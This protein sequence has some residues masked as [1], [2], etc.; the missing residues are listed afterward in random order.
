MSAIRDPGK[1]NE[2]TTLIDI[3]MEDIR[4]ITGVYLVRG[5]KTC[6]IDGGTRAQAPR[7]ARML[8]EAGAFPPDMILVTHPHW[9]HM[10]GIPWLR[11]EAARL[12]KRIEVL[13]LAEAVPL[14]ADASFNAIFAAGPAEAVADVTPLNEGDTIDLGGVVLRVY[15]MPG[16]CPGNLAALDVTNRN[17]FVGDALGDKVADDIFLPP[18]MPP[19]WDPVAFRA[20]LQ[21]MRQ[22]PYD[23]VCLAHFGCV[24]GEEARSIIDEAERVCDAWWAFYERHADRLNDIGF[25][26]KAM[27]Q[28]MHLGTPE[29]RPMTATMSVL[30]A[31]VN[32]A[33]TL[34]G[35]KVALI[36]R[37]A[38]RNVLNW[39]GKG[40]QMH[41][42]ANR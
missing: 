3:G 24:G 22:I 11:Q 33:G 1:I 35:T 23:T 28:E 27:R 42:A 21:R 38:F 4:G 17:L 20:S 12:G 32:G 41:K 18:F 16:H 36:D 13:A 10:E 26:L 25:M 39:L 8:R 31:L 15:E 9:D 14:L 2:N 29:L 7:L 30:L 34:T 37:L 40:Y 5:S 19:R 6:L